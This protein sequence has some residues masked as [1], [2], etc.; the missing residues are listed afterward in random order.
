SGTWT[1]WTT[2]P[3]T[4]KAHSAPAATV[5]GGNLHLF[6][7]GDGALVRTNQLSVSTGAWSGW[8]TLTAPKGATAAPAAAVYGGELRLFLRG[9]QQRIHQ[10]R[11]GL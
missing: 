5:Y 7:R 2:I 11:I 3:G 4:A 8:A 1:G 10:A 6:A 9:A